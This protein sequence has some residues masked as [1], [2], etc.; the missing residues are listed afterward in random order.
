MPH[1]HDR[2]PL[3]SR[4]N[5]AAVGALAAFAWVAMPTPAHAAEMF[6]KPASPRTEAGAEQFVQLVNGS[7]EQSVSSVARERMRDVSVVR[8]T[9][10]THP[11][12]GDWQDKSNAAHLRLRTEEAGTYLVG[13]STAPSIVTM[14]AADFAAYLK[15]DGMP[16]ALAAFERDSR[17]AP[18]RE[19]YSKH[20]RA[21]I[22]AGD[23]RTNEY[24]RPLGY[25]L[26]FITDQNPY[27]LRFGKELGFRLLFRGKPLANQLV[28]AS[29]GGFHGHDAAGN[30]VSSYQLR[31][32]AQGHAP[33]LLSNKGHW[34]LSAIHMQKAAD[35]KADYESNWATLTFHVK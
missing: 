16:D 7:F 2:H 10:I 18:V 25:A 31:T 15:R 3:M 27:D 5:V 30:H 34:Y 1:S 19:R 29:Y 32:D 14:P 17:G 24:S 9:H 35:G 22:Q 28:K 26:E 4:I 6:L 8:G 33:L 20:A 11:A 12:P 13:V 21:L 23:T